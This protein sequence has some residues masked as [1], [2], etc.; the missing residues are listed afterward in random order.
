MEDLFPRGQQQAYDEERRSTIRDI[1]GTVGMSSST[2]LKVIHKD[3][4]MT[5]IAPRWLPHCLTEAQRESRLILAQQNLRKIEDDRSVLNRIIA[6]D[7]SWVYSYDPRSKKADMQWKT[8]DEPRPA[9]VN[10][11]ADVNPVL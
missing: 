7:E 8:Q 11:E 9:A 6:C 2:V 4:K 3:L 5:K 10:Q 1:A